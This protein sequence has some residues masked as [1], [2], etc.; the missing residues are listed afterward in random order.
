MLGNSWA[1]SPSL[2][3]SPFEPFAESNVPNRFGGGFES[4]MINLCT[5]MQINKSKIHCNHCLRGLGA[6]APCAVLD[7]KAGMGR[8]MDLLIKQ[9]CP[10]RFL[11][12][13]IS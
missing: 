3:D 7:R 11:Q 6:A 10:S 1:I 5:R 12:A 2:F 9:L 4:D 8:T 13:F